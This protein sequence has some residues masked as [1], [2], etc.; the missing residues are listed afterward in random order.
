[1]G[2]SGRETRID[3]FGMRGLSAA[4]HL[5]PEP[6]AAELAPLT[7][8]GGRSAI[9]IHGFDVGGFLVDGGKRD[10]S[11]LAP[12]VAR[13][14]FPADWRVVILTPPTPAYWHGDRERDVFATMSGTTADDALCRLVLFGMLP[15]L[16][17]R[18]LAAFGAALGEYNARAGEPFR[19]TQGGTFATASV[20]EVVAWLRSEGIDGA[21]QSSWGPTVF[22]VVGAADRADALARSASAQ[23]DSLAVTVTAGRNRGAEYAGSPRP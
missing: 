3:I 2:C 22:A 17:E 21:G 18:D 7:G 4:N 10:P 8:R 5:R 11:A 1:M 15:A 12:L 20:A 16:A 9:G 13:A 23:W 19:A 14:E 6:S